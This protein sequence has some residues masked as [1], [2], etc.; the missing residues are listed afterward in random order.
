MN[1]DRFHCRKFK[2]HPKFSYVDIYYHKT[3]VKAPPKHLFTTNFKRDFTMLGKNV[4]I[5][6]NN[7]LITKEIE[8]TFNCTAETQWLTVAKHISETIS[9]DLVVLM[10]TYCNTKNKN[11]YFEVY[12]YTPQPMPVSIFR[13]D[14]QHD[15]DDDEEDLSLKP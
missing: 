8:D 2:G 13:S 4:I 11:Q 1:F 12:Y 7:P 5:A 3:P 6:S 10:N 15:S 9:M 14:L